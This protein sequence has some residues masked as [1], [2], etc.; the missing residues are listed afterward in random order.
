MSE[1]RPTAA[2][3]SEPTPEVVARLLDMVAAHNTDHALC[4]M[5][6]MLAQLRATAEEASLARDLLRHAPADILR[7]ALRL[8]AARIEAA[9]IEAGQ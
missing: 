1:Q 2:T 4:D 7:E 8:R 9:R 5:E 3:F 6:Q